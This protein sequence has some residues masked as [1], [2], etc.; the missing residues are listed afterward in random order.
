[1]F[2]CLIQKVVDSSKN[3]PVPKYTLPIK[4]YSTHAVQNYHKFHTHARSAHFPHILTSLDTFWT[5][6]SQL[7]HTMTTGVQNLPHLVHTRNVHNAP[8][9]VHVH[10]TTPRNRHKL[11]L[12]SS[13]CTRARAHVCYKFC[14]TRLDLTHSRSLH[15]R[16]CALTFL[17]HRYVPGAR[18]PERIVCAFALAEKSRW[19]KTKNPI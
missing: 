16:N 10:H 9:H 8:P 17:R 6:C 19:K 4:A 1:M 14:A 2:V 15:M 3:A 7:G 12:L 13:W 18:M 5:P 11:C